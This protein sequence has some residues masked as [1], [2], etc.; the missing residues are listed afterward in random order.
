MR[1]RGGP[2]HGRSDWA[3]WL[4]HF[5]AR[6]QAKCGRTKRWRWR[7]RPADGSAAKGRISRNP[8]AWE[9]AA[10]ME[11]KR[12]E[13]GGLFVGGGPSLVCERG[14]G[15]RVG[16]AGAVAAG[17]D[18]GAFSSTCMCASWNWVRS[19][20]IRWYAPRAQAVEAPTLVALRAPAAAPPP[21]TRSPSSPRSP[22]H[23]ERRVETM[24][25]EHLETMSGYLTA[26]R[27]RLLGL[28]QH[29]KLSNDLD[30]EPHL[31]HGLVGHGRLSL[32]VAGF[33]IRGH[34]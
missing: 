24:S 16:G 9:Y 30:K 5:S 14:V 6:V 3:E 23:R 12:A 13:R 22:H 26:C 2:A 34:P 32:F 4:A 8:P 10:G 11:V 29:V 25:C 19:R 33:I 18:C 15:G 21:P 7:R 17:Y 31:H 1:H 28:P 20:R 27:A